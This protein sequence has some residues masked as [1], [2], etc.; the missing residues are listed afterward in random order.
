M[1]NKLTI[2]DVAK[3]A[4]VSP[5]AV[6]IALNNR[7]GISEKTRNHILEVVK[8]LNFVPN[9]QAR[10]LLL[11]H[12]NNIGMLYNPKRTPLR[13][14]FHF[15]IL[16]ATVAKSAE[17]GYNFIFA[18]VETET[19]EPEVPDIVKNND[20]DGIIILGEIDPKVYHCLQRYEIPLVLIDQHHFERG[21]ISI[22]ADYIH[23]TVTSL[24][25][26]LSLGHK[27]IAYIGEDSSS[28][29]GLLTYQ[30]FRSVLETYQIDIPFSW[31]QTS[32]KD[33][34]ENTGY[35]CMNKI[36]QTN[37]LPSV[38]FCAAD[39]YAIGAIKAIKE[40]G[41]KV[42][43]DISVMGMD[44]IILSRYIEPNLTTIEFDKSA[45]GILAIELLVRLINN[46]KLE[47]DS[48]LFEGELIQRNSVVKY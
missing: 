46:E 35:E 41:L 43:E 47:K 7:K 26:I 13:Q 23:G 3:Y 8:E 22:E 34:D 24:E 17:L 20:V 42:P 45:M 11:N 16:S 40:K 12:T 19:E 25:Y 21:N 29:F 36:L 28:H 31:V 9:Q 44:N 10:R 30:G 37:E 38:V 2:K 27:R 48:Y 14:L 32:A 6:S 1:K 15:D 5:S 18:T 39:I 4:K 33:S